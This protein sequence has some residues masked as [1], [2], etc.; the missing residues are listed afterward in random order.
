VTLLVLRQPAS[1]RWAVT[2]IG[3]ALPNLSIFILDRDLHVVPVGVPGEICIA[4]V[5]VGEGYWRQP[6]KTH[7]A[8]VPCPF[9]EAAAGLMYRTGDL[10]RWLS[11]GSVEFLG[12]IDQQVKI[13]GFRVEPG[14]IEEVM[15]GHAAVQDAAVVAMEDAAGNKRLVGYYVT[16][17]EQSLAPSDL[18]Q[19][20]KDTLADHMVPAA[21]VPLSALPL[22]PLGKLD[23]RALSKIEHVKDVESDKYVAPRS[24]T[25]AVFAAAWSK[26]LRQPRIG[27]Q[28]N[29]FEVGGDSILTLHVIAELRKAGFTLAP[30][31]F[32]LYP[33]IAELV[34]NL[35][36]PHAPSTPKI[37]GAAD[38]RPV[39]PGWDA[40]YLRNQLAAAFPNLEDVYPLSATQRGIYFQSI[41][42]PKASG[43][44]IEQ[45]GF[46]IAGDLDEEAFCMAWQ[47]IVNATEI[48]RTAVIRRAV[49]QPVQVVLRSAALVPDRQDWRR[50]PAAEQ[51]RALATIELSERMKGF[52]LKTPPLMR[53]ALLR[54]ADRRWHVLW[55]YHHIILDGWSEPLLL[56]AM[57]RAYVALAGGQGL[58]SETF[59]PYRDFVAWSETQNLTAAERFWRE[60]LAGFSDP[61]SIKDN[62][63]AVQP[64][65]NLELSHGWHEV[66]L[67]EAE[68][69][70]LEDVA[71]RN[72]LTLGTV[73]HGAWS[74]L[75]HRRTGSQDVVFGSVTSGRQCDMPGC[76]SVRGLLVVTQPTRTR[77]VA[78]A[79]VTS[80]LRLL[81]LQMAE[82][83][84]HEHT[85]LALIQQWC[86]PAVGKRPLL[87]T[88]VVLGNYAGSD[89]TG[90]AP[91]GLA[92]SNVSYITQPMYALTL[93]VVAGKQ[94]SVRLVYDKRRYALETVRKLLDEYLQILRSIVEN[95]EQR[96]G[97]VVGSLDAAATAA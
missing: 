55:T 31:Q 72:R 41:L 79:T 85:P 37:A 89:L 69:A 4:G 83:R 63:P 61:V 32:F 25:E 9:P 65:S 86:E 51:N 88:L 70:Q 87:D 73:M 29:F 33:T 96:L 52:D 13:R 19:Y 36:R 23:R 58:P 91:P 90:C 46:D 64:P 30:K 8:F 67:T 47:H 38:H 35:H 20:L 77:L 50:L 92:I 14:E 3:P 24:E 17:K 54:L 18:R 1:E 66:S 45:I 12:R 21:L 62:S 94:L 84:E 81:Q 40:Q 49:P 75:L 34:A 97:G 15:T 2:P 39:E 43:A 6:E 78:D 95:P 71:R 68:T 11:D 16:H 26:V 7:A 42:A 48:L 22:T 82:M 59:V 57:F 27:V 10:G 93:F 76:E 5:G 56:S 44:Y 60:Q 80:W 53:V 28:D 74:L